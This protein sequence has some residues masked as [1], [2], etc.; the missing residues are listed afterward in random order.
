MCLA[1][2]SWR[3]AGVG[4]R[5]AQSGT[6]SVPRFDRI[7]SESNS[8]KNP[9]VG[10]NSPAPGPL[11]EALACEELMRSD[12]GFSMIELL[13]VVAVILIIAAIAVPNFLKSRLPVNESSAGAFLRVINTN[14][15][16]FSIT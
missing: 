15:G 6:L 5:C 12:K 7:E 8:G 2:S 1:L 11:A 16:T 9:P 13:L 4:F 3:H 14:A 10:L